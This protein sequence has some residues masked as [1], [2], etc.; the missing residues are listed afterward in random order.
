MFLFETSATNKYPI[1][2]FVFNIRF[3]PQETY[4]KLEITLDGYDNVVN[5]I[6]LRL[7]LLIC[8]MTHIMNIH[9]VS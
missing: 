5:D 3:T 2:I 9:N 1:N 6:I 7:T 4:F 8:Q